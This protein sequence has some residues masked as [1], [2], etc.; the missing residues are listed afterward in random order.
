V[1]EPGWCAGHYLMLVGNLRVAVVFFVSPEGWRYERQVVIPRYLS[2][3]PTSDL[4]HSV[5]HTWVPKLLSHGC[6]V[7]SIPTAVVLQ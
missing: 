1:Y 3:H 5:L 6:D 4:I 7:S 2:L